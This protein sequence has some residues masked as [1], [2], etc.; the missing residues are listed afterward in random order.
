M[1]PA[2]IEFSLSMSQ[3]LFVH[4]DCETVEGLRERFGGGAAIVAGPERSA[5]VVLSEYAGSVVFVSGALLEDGRY[6]QVA[7]ALHIHLV[8]VYEAGAAEMPLS[9]ADDIIVLPVTQAELAARVALAHRLMASVGERAELQGHLEHAERVSAIGTLAA[10]VAHEINNPMAFVHSNLQFLAERLNDLAAEAPVPKLPELQLAVHEAFE[11][12]ARVKR[13]VGDLKTFARGDEEDVGPVDVVKALDAAVRLT[14]NQLRHRASL[15]V[16]AGSVPPVSGVESRLTQVFVNLIV[17]AIHALPEGDPEANE[18]TLRVLL[19]EERVVVTV[20]D[21]GS[22]ISPADL[23]RIFDPFFSTK[24]VGIG[25]GL[26]LSVCERIVERFGGDLSVESELGVGATFRVALPMA[27]GAIVEAP[28][29]ERLPSSGTRGRVLVV[30]DDVFVLRGFDRMLRAE[31]DVVTARDGQEA[32]ER[33]AAGEDFD[34]V[35][36]DLMMPVMNGLEVY[37][38]VRIHYPD[39]A[40][41]F[42]FLSGGVLEGTLS[43]PDGEVMARLLY[44]P[45]A[46]ATILALIE[47]HISDAGEATAPIV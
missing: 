43:D 23:E 39:V 15:L 26:G 46:K 16:D 1:L 6:R 30:D 13:I 3:V 11:G 2:G 41:R 12:V 28:E 37:R 4:E 5:S 42:Y 19:D 40:T 24:P 47:A 20:A 33:L 32:L 44:K 36:C 27:A 10:G 22:G 45:V 35:L 21:N 29:P 25:T 34:L 14:Q 38:T 31:H 8:A 17:N 7:D 18:I 9:G